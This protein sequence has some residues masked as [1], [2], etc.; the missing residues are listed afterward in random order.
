MFNK[1][2]RLNYQPWGV[3][4]IITPWNYPF[5][6]PFSELVMALLAG[7]A[8]LFKAASATPGVGRLLETIF[9]QAS[10]PEGLFNYV[11][12]PGKEAGPAFI[13]AGIDKLFFTGSTATGK[14]LMSLASERLMPLVLELGGA[15]AAVICADADLDKAAFGVL[16]SGYS[17]A[18]Q[19][20]GGAQR[21]LVDKRVY[22]AFLEKLCKQVAALRPGSDEDAGL[23]PMTPVKQK[24]LVDEQ[25][26]DCVK[27]GA[28]IAA[29]SQPLSVK[30]GG[31]FAGK[32]M[33]AVV[34]TVPPELEKEKLFKMPIMAGEVFGPACIV[35]PF[36]NDEEAVALANASSYGL[37]ASVWSRNHGRARQLALRIR[38]GAV[39]LNDHLMSHG[40]AETP[41]GGPGDSGLGRSHGKPGFREMLR[42]Q[43]IV[44]DVLPCTSRMLWWHPYSAKVYQGLRAVT[45][46]LACG[47]GGKIKALPQVL[48]MVGR[49]WS[50]DKN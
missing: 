29:Q 2:S 34:L 41:W 11:E 43:V 42:M 37:T 21:I 28:T 32:F 18:G 27:L 13:N 6:I 39:M 22:Q 15:D 9:K 35:L 48:Y 47:L 36:E 45:R 1:R 12:M 33:P 38:A 26:R 7:N 19:S 31:P 23:G 4:G 5:S 46:F 20:C 14:T 17:N 25:I 40:L 24:K 50:K 30:E 44:D 10:L 3:I 16:W 8:V 49:Y